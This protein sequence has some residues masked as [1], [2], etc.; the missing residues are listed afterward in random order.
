MVL[1]SDFN[2]QY[3]LMHHVEKSILYC[4][5]YAIIHISRARYIFNQIRFKKYKTAVMIDIMLYFR[6]NIPRPICKGAEHFYT[7][8]YVIFQPK[9]KTNDTRFRDISN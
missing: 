8:M 4:Q 1:D 5:T 2:P 6:A 9:R 7:C 3:S